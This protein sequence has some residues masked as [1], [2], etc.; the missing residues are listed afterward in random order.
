MRNPY[1]SRFG[2]AQFRILRPSFAPLFSLAIRCRGRTNREGP[3]GE[4]PEGEGDKK[5]GRR[6]RNA[7]KEREGARME[8]GRDGA[9]ER[10]RM[11]EGRKKKKRNKFAN[12]TGGSPENTLDV[13]RHLGS[14]FFFLLLRHSPR[15]PPMLVPRA[16]VTSPILIL[17]ELHGVPGVRGER[18]R[19]EREGGRKGGRRDG[20][21]ASRWKGGPCAST[22]VGLSCFRTL[23]VP[24]IRSQF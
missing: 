3:Q 18:N 15:T 4:G 22:S 7:P 20:P 5:R 13:W 10:E 14:F 16:F 11:E 21:R 12:S 9:S 1:L 8:G 17:R 19:R 2:L 24:S 23:F 6:A